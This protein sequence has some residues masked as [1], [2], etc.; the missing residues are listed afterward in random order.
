MIKNFCIQNA[1][2]PPRFF[3]QNYVIDS[4]VRVRHFCEYESFPRK[5]ESPAKNKP[6]KKK[7]PVFTGMTIKQ[8]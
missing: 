2:L 1:I 4:S 5:R 7:I 8:K 3:G 6:Y